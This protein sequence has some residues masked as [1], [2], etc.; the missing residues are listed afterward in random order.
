[1]VPAGFSPNSL[2]AC[3][4]GV[5]LLEP[6]AEGPQQALARLGGRH[7][8]RGAGQQPQPEP[9]LQAADGLAQRRLRHAELRGGPGEAPLPR[10]REEG[11]EVVEVRPRH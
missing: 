9:C 7:A 2:T 3:K 6:R 8:A 1:M 5:D 11:E 4:L 10:D